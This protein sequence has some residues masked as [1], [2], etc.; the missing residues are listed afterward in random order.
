MNSNEQIVLYGWIAAY[1]ISG[2]VIAVKKG[3]PI[4]VVGGGLLAS[5]GVALALSYFLLPR[6][7][8]GV[9]Q[10]APSVPHLRRVVQPLVAC[11]DLGVVLRIADFHSSG[12]I[13]GAERFAKQAISSAA[14]EVIKA[15]ELLYVNRRS[16]SGSLARVHRQGDLRE[17][18]TDTTGVAK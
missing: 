15:G 8:H 7:Q 14:C 2:V 17:L 1:F 9:E 18:W 3:G 6:A 16:A 4:S 11:S 12:D 5:L 13:Q 10:V